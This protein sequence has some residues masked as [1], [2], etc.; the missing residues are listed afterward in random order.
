MWFNLVLEVNYKKKIPQKIILLDS[1]VGLFNYLVDY[2]IC[3]IL[4]A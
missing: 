1:W 2:V 4:W 3:D